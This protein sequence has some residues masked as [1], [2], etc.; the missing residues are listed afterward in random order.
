MKKIRD[1]S[2]AQLHAKLVKLGFKRGGFVGYYSLPEP[3]SNTNVS[4]LNA[5]TNRRAQLA[6]M[7]REFNKHKTDRLG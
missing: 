2:E 6:Y 7:V 5:G 1:L 3:C 4:K